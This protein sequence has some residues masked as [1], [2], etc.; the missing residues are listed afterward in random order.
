MTEAE[1]EKKCRKYAKTKGAW[2]AKWVSPGVSGVP[3]DILFMPYKTY[4]MT[5]DIDTAR[6]IL[7]E[8]KRKGKKAT[9]LQ[10]HYIDKLTD[11]GFE[12]VIIDDFEDFKEL[13]R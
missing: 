3:D 12:A 6:V 8:F 7:I 4:Y 2:L 1:L 11:M 10:Q 5:L 13:F 9:K